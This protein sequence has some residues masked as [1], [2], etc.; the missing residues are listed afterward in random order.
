MIALN[1]QY[2]TLRTDATVDPFS[3]QTAP[4]PYGG[5]CAMTEVMDSGGGLIT[6]ASSLSRF[7]FSNNVYVNDITDDPG[8]TEHIRDG[9]IT[10]TSAAA[11]SFS[12]K[13]GSKKYDMA[14]IFNQF[15]KKYKQ[16]PIVNAPLDRFIDSLT[17]L[18]QANF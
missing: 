17:T 18:V 7:I 2:V 9:N 13:D 1:L 3:P 8:R 4:L 16:G 6:S 11:K 15:D 14:V 5:F 12:S 10:G